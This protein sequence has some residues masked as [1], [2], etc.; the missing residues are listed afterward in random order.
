MQATKEWKILEAKIKAMESKVAMR[1]EGGKGKK[2]KRGGGGAGKSRRLQCNKIRGSEFFDWYGLA[3]NPTAVSSAAMKGKHRG[4][5]SGEKLRRGES[6]TCNKAGQKYLCCIYI[7]IY[8][9]PKLRAGAR[10]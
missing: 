1:R 7:I 10:S 5:T 4:E 3:V 2:G 6:E 9:F 8:V